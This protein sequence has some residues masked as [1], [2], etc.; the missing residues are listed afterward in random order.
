MKRLALAL[1]AFFLAAGAFA[2]AADAPAAPHQLPDTRLTYEG[3]YVRLKTA[4]AELSNIAGVP[5]ECGSDPTDWRVR[6]I[7]VFISVKDLPLQRVLELLATTA[8]V[9]LVASGGGYRLCRTDETQAA[10]DYPSE[11][12]LEIASKQVIWAWEVLEAYGKMPNAQQ[13]PEDDSPYGVPTKAV[14]ILAR[15]VASLSP[16]LKARA[17]AG[18]TIKLRTG[19]CPQS[20]LLR[21]LHAVGCEVAKSRREPAIPLTAADAEDAFLIIRAPARSIDYRSAITFILGGLP[22]GKAQPSY[23]Y[24]DLNRGLWNIGG[25]SEARSLWRLLKSPALPA[26][27]TVRPGQQPPEPPIAPGL[28]ELQKAADWAIVPLQTSLTL[29]NSEGREPRFSDMMM[30]ISRSTGLSILVEDFYS[31]NPYYLDEDVVKRLSEGQVSVSF[32]R[33]GDMRWYYSEEEKLLVA[34]QRSWRHRHRGLV[35]TDVL[36][37]FRAKLDGPG[38]ELED[39]LDVLRLNRSQRF[40][41][42]GWSEFPQLGSPTCIQDA[43]F[44]QLYVALTKN[45]QQR[46][47]STE[48]LPLRELGEHWASDFLVAKLREITGGVFTTLPHDDPDIEPVRQLI[49][50]PAK[51]ARASL[52]LRS[53]AVRKGEYYTD[54]GG[55]LRMSG[56]SFSFVSSSAA[57][58]DMDT[59]KTRYWLEL[60]LEG[61]EKPA[62]EAELRKAFPILS[63][64]R[65]P[66]WMVPHDVG[67]RPPRFPAIRLPAGS[68]NRGEM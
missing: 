31:Q 38:M 2:A 43:P 48:G 52:H 3:G 37:G 57:P 15:I 1:I 24:V 67:R 53:D 39:Y 17:L 42:A 19:K 45:Q 7:P 27:P 22:K 59:G 33:M 30:A 44:W 12:Q 34:R 8:H 10:L 5:I 60:R 4:A 54:L 26:P 51:L 13:L 16:E 56:L 65:E 23:G 68:T 63:L 21:Q 14:Q 32:R 66:R 64:A 50:D 28:I 55:R 35:P 58:E 18:D 41:S 40:Q 46:V 9:D 47:A 36:A 62:V 25:Y 29:E 6:D 61:E 49:S 11:E 20:E